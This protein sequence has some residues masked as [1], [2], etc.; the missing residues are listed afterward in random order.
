MNRNLTALALAAVF[1]AGAASGQPYPSKPIRIVTAA[2]GGATDYAARQIAQGISGSLGQQIIIDNRPAIIQGEIVS[3]APPDGYTLYVAGDS[4]WVQSLLQK[5]PY[6][7]ARDFSPITWAMRAPSILSVHPSLPVRSVKDLIALA[8]GRPGELNYS[9]G[10]NGASAHLAME[11]LK[12]MTGVNV[13][14][15]PYKGVPPGI[16]DLASGQVQMTFSS[17]TSV[18]PYIKSGRVNALAVTSPEQSTLFPDLPTVAASVPGYEAQSMMTLLAPAKTPEA[19][20]NRL[21]QETV[22]YLRTAAAKERFFNAG[23]EIVASSP[24]QLAAAMKADM[25]RWGKVIADAGIKAD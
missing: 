18:A 25:V 24:E 19:V 23:L 17:M 15:I 5:V 8:K 20:I 13:V 11:L 10:G 3:K 22:R 16:V 14:H 12:S 7:V 4:L 21:N 9:S 6:D 2:A 1:G